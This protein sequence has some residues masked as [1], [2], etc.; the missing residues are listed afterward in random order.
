MIQRVQWKWAATFRLPPNDNRLSSLT[1]REAIEQ[2][3]AYQA[4]TEPPGTTKLPVQPRKDGLVVK[5]A[6]PHEKRPYDGAQGPVLTGD[7]EWD[8]LELAEWDPAKDAESAA[9]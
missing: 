3:N 7:P 8:A 2:I 6:E 1:L 9:E 5:Y 4:F